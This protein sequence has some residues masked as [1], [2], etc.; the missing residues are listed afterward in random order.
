MG[1]KTC[2]AAILLLLT[3][4]KVPPRALPKTT[5]ATEPVCQP[6]GISVANL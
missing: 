1:A 6:G 3:A 5:E 4:P 2:S